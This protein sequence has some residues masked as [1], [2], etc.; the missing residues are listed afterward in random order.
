MAGSQAIAFMAAFRD[1]K[2]IKLLLKV[3]ILNRG[4]TYTKKTEAPFNIQGAYNMWV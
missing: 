2:Y 4:G 3:D 1:E